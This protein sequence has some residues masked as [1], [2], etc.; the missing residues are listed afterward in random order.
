MNLVL[1]SSFYMNENVKNFI[2][3]KTGKDNPTICIIPSG[4]YY[5]GIENNS[6]YKDLVKNGFN[7]SDIF[8]F[9]AVKEFEP[10]KINRAFNSDVII[11]CGGN[12]FIF[13]FILE[14]R[15]LLQKLKSF[16]YNGGIIIGESAGSILMSKDIEIARF[17]DE[18]YIGGDTNAIGLVGFDFKPHFDYWLSKL[19]MFIKYSYDK[20]R[21]LYCVFEEG[22]III[23]DKN[24]DIYGD[25]I[26][27]KN[28]NI[29]SWGISN[30]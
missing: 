17:A 7:G 29:L 13:R 10:D 22:Y 23:D 18:D 25:Y 8:I 14:Y 21:D 28:G 27:I 15:G 3:N 6:K 2:K 20:A 16:A 9:D 26:H 30:G 5:G 24:M 11:L 12:T 19:K 1:Y 4:P